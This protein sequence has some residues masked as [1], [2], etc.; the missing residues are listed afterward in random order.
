[1]KVM[2]WERGGVVVGRRKQFRGQSDFA[3]LVC[4]KPFGKLF[5]KREGRDQ[6]ELCMRNS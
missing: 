4:L 1:M 6:W 3:P 5:H 2:G